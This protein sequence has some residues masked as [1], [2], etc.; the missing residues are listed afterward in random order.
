MVAKKKMVVSA[1]AALVSFG[2]LGAGYFGTMKNASFSVNT[3]AAS[4]EAAENED[5]KLPGVPNFRM[6]SFE[7]ANSATPSG[8]RDGV[9][10]RSGQPENT[11]TMAAALK[12]YIYM[13]G[14]VDIKIN[15][16]TAEFTDPDFGVKVAF[17]SLVD[18]GEPANW[19]AVMITNKAGNFAHLKDAYSQIAD[20]PRGAQ[21]LVHC[22]SGASRTGFFF[23]ALEW[24]TGATKEQILAD[25]DTTPNH[26]KFN[27]AVLASMTTIKK[28]W[29]SI[30]GYFTKGLGLTEKQVQALKLNLANPITAIKN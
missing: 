29:G 21:F 25:Y 28:H 17:D 15:A 1:L 23:F 27:A 10:Y 20:A 24:L 6:V 18:P 8:I 19:E 13:P 3:Q 26:E 2:L 11:A 7:V 12:K 9:I 16:N 30:D 5:K 22:T 4:T 14:S